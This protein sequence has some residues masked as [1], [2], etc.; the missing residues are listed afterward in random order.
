MPELKPLHGDNKNGTGIGGCPAMSARKKLFSAMAGL[1]MMA[2]PVSALA[3]DHHHNWS[4]NF[5]A[6][7]AIERKQSRSDVLGGPAFASN[8][9]SAYGWNHHDW[10][11]RAYNGGNWLRNPYSGW[12][13][14]PP[15]HRP[16]PPPVYSYGPPAGE[17]AFNPP[18]DRLTP[19]NFNNGTYGYGNGYGGGNSYGYGNPN[20]D[21]G[22]S[23]QG[24]NLAAE[25]DRLLRERAGAFQQLAIREHNGDRD[26]AHHLWNTIHSLNDQLGRVNAMMNRRG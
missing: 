21:G 25:R 7:P 12:N 3:G 19:P 6:R 24:G 17:Y 4:Q 22:Y 10:D 20:D 18:C 2:I 26:G 8:N 23:Y 15:R 16:I 13:A 11:Q 1:A 5:P 14:A 9:R